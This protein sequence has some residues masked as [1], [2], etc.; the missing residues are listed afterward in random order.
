MNRTR[1]KICGLT[2]IQDVHAAVAAGV[3][4][5]GFVFYPKSPRYVEPE[6]AASL[7]AAIPP[8]ISTVGLFVNA[9]SLEIAATIAQAPI[10][11]LQ[12]HGD[13]T[14]EQCCDA[15]DFVRRP[16]MRAVRIQSD[17]AASDLLNVEKK[18]HAASA[19]FSGLLLD[20][21]VD[22][23][24]GAGKVFDWSMIPKEL[25]PR[26]ILSG[27][28][29]VQNAFDAVQRVRPYA[30]D[31]SSGVELAKGIKDAEKMHAFVQAVRQAD[32]AQIAT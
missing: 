30:V 32:A 22:T 10:S 21:F 28:L 31:I 3:D 29:C 15:A 26:I 12:F 27:G 23:Y 24:G 18:Y 14:M 9:S 19:L 20:A 4:A 1:I 25:A 17:M 7:I 8:F 11:L 13:E 6:L 5:I 2:R 16:Y